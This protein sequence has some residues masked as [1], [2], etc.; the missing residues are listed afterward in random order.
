MK[1]AGLVLH[2]PIMSGLRVITKSRFLACWDIYPN[3]SRIELV[4]APVFIIHGQDDQQVG[5]SHGIGLYEKTPDSYK[6]PPWW[7]PKKGH[8]DVLH[9]NEQEF[10][11]RMRSFINIV[12]NSVRSPAIEDTV[13][14][15]SASNIIMRDNPMNEADL[16]MQSL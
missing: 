5:C 11:L 10:I 3:I 2:S 15:P 13:R 12:D 9:G 8:N 16:S 4:R 1:V 7:V 14:A 6:T